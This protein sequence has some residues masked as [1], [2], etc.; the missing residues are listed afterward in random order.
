MASNVVD[1]IL[2]RDDFGTEKMRSIFSDE[3]RL[4]KWLDVEVA[5][6]KVESELNIIPEEAYVEILKKGRFDLIDVKEFRDELI[7]TGHPLMPLIKLFKKA[8][9][10]NAGQYIHWGATTQDVLDTGMILQVKE[11]YTE[12][13]EK[14][15]YLNK[16][17]C[18]Q[19][20][21]YR[22]LVM[23][24]RTNG[25]QALPIT[26][27][28]KFAIWANEIQRDIER[29]KDCKNRVL[30]GQFSGAVGTL[31]SLGE[32]G[33]KVQRMLLD[34]LGLNTPDITWNTSRDILVELTCILALINSTIGKIGT[35]VYALQK[36]ETRELE[37][38]FDSNKVGS[39]TMPHKRNPFV[40]MQLETLAKVSRSMVTLA[41]ETMPNE[42]ERDARGLAV[43]WDYISRICCTT[44]CALEKGIHLVENLIVYPENI[45]KNIDKLKGL[46]FSEAIMMKL[47]KIFGR[48]E[49]HDILHELSMEAL[50]K[51]IPMKDMLLANEIISKNISEE[52]IDFI[53]DPK[54]YLG[55][56]T[57]FVDKVVEKCEKAANEFVM[58]N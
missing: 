20:N 33:M 43:E 11:A 28:F 25:Q 54:N 6:A 1:S 29:L 8:C 7:K 30:V 40:S 3:N 50:E 18:R 16:V 38:Y 44:D 26:L 53:L 19:A 21:K 4:Q 57:S 37:E 45:E 14:V 12:I 56:A 47:S 34:E 31:A 48:Q 24:G 10:N 58:N 13:L 2:Y 35:E 51:D 49:A 36:T 27:G 46:V 23:I 22:D 52:E 5:L 55:F 17:L 15:E 42:H 9:D 41:Y 39:S 32:D